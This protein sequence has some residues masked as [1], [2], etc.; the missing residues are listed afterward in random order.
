MMIPIL[1]LFVTATYTPASPAI[2]DRVTINYSAPVT[3]QPSPDFEIVSRKP[4]QVVIRTF[5]T[6]PITVHASAA[7]GEPAGD[8]V[9]GIRSVLAPNDALKPAPLQPPRALAASRTP[10]IAIAIAALI[11]AAVWMLAWRRSRRTTAAEIESRVPPDERF[12]LA[13]QA[14]AR[15]RLRWAALADATRTYL[16]AEYPGLGLELTTEELLRLHAMPPPLQTI[17]RQGD[18][19]KFAPWGAQPG[20]FDEAAKSAIALIRPKPVVGGAE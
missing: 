1:V 10:W 5:D 13:V 11:A 2:G 17:L 12:R 8:V 18:L 16:A 9:I 15:H 7:N 19:E 6:H 20:D 14:A 4:A 3:V